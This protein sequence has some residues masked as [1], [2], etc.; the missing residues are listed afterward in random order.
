MHAQ[1][2]T[3]NDVPVGL[4]S[5]HDGLV[6][7]CALLLALQRGLGDADCQCDLRYGYSAASCNPPIA[8]HASAHGCR[9]IDAS[10]ACCALHALNFRGVASATSVGGGRRE[11]STLRTSV[12]QLPGT[13]RWSRTGDLHV[14]HAHGNAAHRVRDK[15]V[16]FAR[17]C[18]RS[19]CLSC[20]GV[21]SGVVP[22]CR[23][24]RQPRGS[25]GQQEAAP[26][27][28]ARPQVIAFATAGRFRVQ[29]ALCACCASESTRPARRTLPAGCPVLGRNGAAAGRPGQHGQSKREESCHLQ[30]SDRGNL[31][32]GLQARVLRESCWQLIRVLGEGVP[33]HS[34]SYNAVCILQRSLLW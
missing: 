3:N 18:S 12:Q 23:G 20:H 27:A 4:C 14:W 33:M 29:F 15:S 19:Q 24:H 26:P 10:V 9:M 11:I 8:V 31:E 17:C 22:A 13:V 1:W 25:C 21:C 16:R 2:R 7:N 34:S 28:G 6:A 30:Q 32:D 5:R